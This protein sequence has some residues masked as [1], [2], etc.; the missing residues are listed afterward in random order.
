MKTI[1]FS[2]KKISTLEEKAKI[3]NV[4]KEHFD[5][6]EKCKREGHLG[7]KVL[8]TNSCGR[9]LCY[10]NLCREMYSR[11]MTSDEHYKFNEEVKIKYTI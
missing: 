2:G 5:R 4:L 11:N 3:N 6:I 1:K 7:E 9:A 10:C 8:S